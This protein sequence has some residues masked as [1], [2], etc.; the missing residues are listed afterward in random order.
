[1]VNGNVC[2]KQIYSIYPI[3]L[4]RYDMVIDFLLMSSLEFFSLQLQ[5]LKAVLAPL[6]NL[7]IVIVVSAQNTG[8]TR[9]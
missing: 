1:M 6:H 3:T 7:M 4:S 5:V 2:S 8:L 9:G